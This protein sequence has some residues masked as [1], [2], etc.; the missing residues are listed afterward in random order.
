MDTDLD[1]SISP[2]GSGIEQTHQQVS[3]EEVKKGPTR[4]ELAEQAGTR[5]Q[6][7]F[8]RVDKSSG[9][10]EEGLDNIKGSSNDE[11]NFT[12]SNRRV[13]SRL[14]NVNAGDDYRARD[15]VEETS[16]SLGYAQK[17]VNEQ[18]EDLL[19]VH[20]RGEDY[21]H[22]LRTQSHVWLS[23]HGLDDFNKELLEAAKEDDIGERSTKVDELARKVLYSIE[24]IDQEGGRLSG[25]F[26]SAEENSKLNGSKVMQIGSIAYE[27][28]QRIR[29]LIGDDYWSIKGNIEEA[30][31]SA[32]RLFGTTV[33]SLDG[34]SGE[35]RSL[36][37]FVAETGNDLG[38][39]FEAIKQDDQTKT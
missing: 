25:E 21:V 35:L 31:E 28:M 7:F 39:I 11:V 37:H 34:M 2:E 32:R 33:D 18:V 16:G 15:V 6:E 23:Q 12:E 29:D 14:Q 1:V 26:G 30:E 22:L 17:L 9:R 3:Q 13:I 8:E 38:A 10:L 4:E 19:R 36:S 5:M 20:G 27:D 24:E